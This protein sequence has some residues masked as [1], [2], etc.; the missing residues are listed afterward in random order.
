MTDKEIELIAAWAADEAPEG[1]TASLP[2]P[3]TF[4]DGW[5]LGEPD[6]LLKMS[7]PFR[8]PAG[9]RD[10]YRCFVIPIPLEVSKLISGVEFRPGNAK[11]VHHAIMFLD[12]NGAAKQLEGLDGKPGFPSFGGP[13]IKP[14]GGL[15]SWTPGSMPRLLPDGLVK[16]V[17]QGSDLVLQVHYHPTGKVENDQSVVGIHFS[18]KPMM[19]KIVTGIAVLQTGLKIPA[20]DAHCEITAESHPLP[21][22]VNVLALT[23]HMHNLGREFRV[24]A[25]LP[26]N[27]EVPLVWIKDWD[28]NW[29]GAYQFDKPIK[30]PK[31]S[32]ISVKSTYDNSEANPKNPFKPPKAIR[33]GEQTTDEMCLCGVQ[34]FADRSSDLKLIAEMRGN[35]LGACLEGGIPGQ[36]EGE[37]KKATAQKMADKYKAEKEEIAKKIAER[38]QS[39]LVASAA[40]PPSE[41]AEDEPEEKPPVKGKK[42]TGKAGGAFPADGLA[43]PENA[44]L[45]LG[46]YDLDKDGRL[47]REEFKAMP[48]TLQVLIRRGASSKPGS[49]EPAIKLD[50]TA[51]DEET[52]KRPATSKPAAKSRTAKPA[53]AESADDADAAAS[54]DDP[55]E[56]PKPKARATTRVKT[57]PKAASK[58]GT[59]YPLAGFLI[60]EDCREVFAK[61]DLNRDGRLARGEYDKMPSA[62]KALVRRLLAPQPA[63]AMASEPAEPEPGRAGE[64]PADAVRPKKSVARKVAAPPVEETAADDASEAAHEPPAKP[65]PKS[66][67][68]TTAQYP[69]GGVPIPENVKLLTAN[70]DLDKDGK[71]SREEYD[72]LPDVWKSQVR[73]L[74]GLKDVPANKPAEE[75]TAEEPVAQGD[76][77]APE[78]KAE[79]PAKPEIPAKPVAKP[80]PPYPSEGLAIPENFRAFMTNFDTNKD[81]RISKEEFDKLPGLLKDHFRRNA[82]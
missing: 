44:R 70:F 54:G 22:N 15:G 12:A 52:K 82:K 73:K 35:E 57:P 80:E 23:P 58:G 45:F 6:L 18:K 8:V 69:A 75:G 39:Q 42:A 7:E 78:P 2:P 17:A 61:Y 43:I 31:G 27:S 29:Q 33:W 76:P 46:Q 81:G 14:T 25:R 68:K 3:P 63:V 55:A 32:T 13:V 47:S 36:A 30:L 79:A 24:V 71:I 66:V 74:A 64:E 1:D 34:V 37:R 26:N 53:A 4:P 77:A 5:Q 60:P 40:A 51:S 62:W 48:E 41:V 11:V 56:E 9:G 19:S 67:A 49:G 50:A 20:G 28:F 72:K 38:R 65:A 10:I 21:V 59:S 16:Y